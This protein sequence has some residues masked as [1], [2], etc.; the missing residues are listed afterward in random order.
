MIGSLSY[1]TLNM[2]DDDIFILTKNVLKCK[3]G[4]GFFK[5][6]HVL[7]VIYSMG[8]AHSNWEWGNGQKHREKKPD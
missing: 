2:S 3:I 5:S 4:T 1:F 7:K 6:A 8:H